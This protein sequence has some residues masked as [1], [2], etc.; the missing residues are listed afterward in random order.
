[1]SRASRAGLVMLP[2]AAANGAS[3]QTLLQ[4]EPNM[5][6]ATLP[7]PRAA[8]DEASRLQ[9][10][11]QLVAGPALAVTELQLPLHTAEVG[12]VGGARVGAGAVAALLGSP[13]SI[14]MGGGEDR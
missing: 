13:H 4:K 7:L 10:E 1:M 6:V 9:T 12:G 8:A 5:A 11:L 14:L 3:M 2:R